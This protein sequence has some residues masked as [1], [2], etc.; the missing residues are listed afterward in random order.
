MFNSFILNN[1]L[2]Q[3]L[4]LFEKNYTIYQVLCFTYIKNL[5]KSEN[6]KIM[7]LPEKLVKD[8]EEKIKLL[9]KIDLSFNRSKTE[10]TYTKQIVSAR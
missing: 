10:K 5:S 9:Q 4:W 8:T 7:Q 3:A 1:M 2:D 6:D